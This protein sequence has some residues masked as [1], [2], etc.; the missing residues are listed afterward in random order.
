MDHKHSKKNTVPSQHSLQD[1]QRMISCF[2]DEILPNIPSKEEIL[3][4]AK[5]RRLQR[6]KVGSSLLSLVGVAIGLYWYNP[7]YQQQSYVSQLGEQKQVM[8]SDGSQIELNT[9]TKI[10]VQ[11]HLRSREIV[12]L[13]G[14]AMFT[15]AHGQNPVSR[16][17]ERDFTVTAGD[18]WIRDIGTIFNVDKH[19]DDEV[20][21]T[22]LE[23]EVE[24]RRL[25]GKSLSMHLTEQQSI[26]YQNEQ[27]GP[28]K[29]IDG[30]A[31]TA[32][33]TGKIVFEQ[34][35]LQE[36][37]HNFQRYSDFTVEIEYDQLK[38]IPINGQFQAKNYQQFMQALPHVAPVKIQ[39]INEH[40]WKVERK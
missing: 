26:H 22:V 18:V 34:K 9:N 13:Q 33:Q 11:Q 28:V 20:M 3:Q 32:W 24:V 7:S 21:V 5:Q 30:Y 10:T 25:N 38:Q 37:I 4:R 29:T 8:L 31:I 39:K 15:V 40:H 1:I 17:F 36:A 35:P 19:R 16:L 12:L 2:E 23:G 6:Q 27:F 14:E